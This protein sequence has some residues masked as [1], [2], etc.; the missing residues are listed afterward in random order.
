MKMKRFAA[1]IL[2]GT[3]AF[4]L[5]ACGSRT[6]SASGNTDSG[7]S[8]SGSAASDTS[9][10]DIQKAGKIRI[11][12]E[13]DW[14]PFSYHDTDDNLVG[15]DV[16]VAQN[17]AKELGVEAEITEAPWDGLLTGLSTGVYDI[18]VNGV[19]I[20]PDREETFDFS[21]PY[22][23]DHIDL[24][25]KK[26]NTDITSF[27]DLKG[28]TSANSTGSTYAELG[29]Q[30][31]AAV[32]NVPTLAETMELVLN[33]TV[34][35]TINADTSVQDYLNTTG[36]TDLKVVSQLDDVTSYAIPL[37]KGSDSLKEAVNAAI[38]KMRDDGTL[39][40]LSKKYF[41]ADLTNK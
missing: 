35:A 2:A 40:E 20:T 7:A 14:Q 11:G 27:D 18:V 37:K 41:G 23:Y 12:L 22:A 25:V 33:G 10:A 3:M 26:E 38:Q 39:A 19:D 29:E 17:I 16:E 9:L 21:D 8:S 4:S 13:G 31:G 15:Y 28:R 1:M 34:D 24:V 36:E 30:Y 5:A 6:D 32:S